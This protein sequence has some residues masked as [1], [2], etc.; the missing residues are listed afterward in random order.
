MTISA[1]Q[2]PYGGLTRDTL[3]SLLAAVCAR[4]GL[5]PDH[6]ELIKF[7]NNAVFRLRTEPVVV[8]IA[9]STAAR[10][11][12][13]TVVRV[14]RW[15]ES[16]GFPAVRLL[17]GIEQPMRLDGQVITLWQRVPETGPRPDG[18]DLAGLLRRLHRLPA[19]PLALPD[20]HPMDEVRQRLAEPEELDTDDHE[21]LLEECDEIEDQLAMLRFDLPPGVIH[22][23]AFMGNVIAGPRGPVLCD[24]DGTSIGPREWDLA[25]VA[26][27]RLRLDYPT[28]DHALLAKGYGFDVTGWPGFPVLRRLRELKLVT[29]VLPILRSNPGIREQ[30]EHRMRTYRAR[31]LSARWQ[32]YR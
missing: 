21:F 12:A 23:D 4:T 22:G 25:P 31:D 1:V 27:G 16:H 24:F 20:W 28:D 7:T 8:R 3:H 14:A 13:V 30:W 9:G 10:D 32:P 5:D 26:V 2:N 11:R 29:S 18:A 15:L 6:A 19:P 17:P